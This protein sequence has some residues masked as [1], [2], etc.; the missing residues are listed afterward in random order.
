MED[1]LFKRLRLH[2]RKKLSFTPG[3]DR[4]RVLSACKDYLRLEN[5]MSLRYHR[6]GDSG[7][8]VAFARACMIDVLIE[9]LFAHVLK[10]LEEQTETANETVSVVALGGYGRAELCPL[11]D[12]DLMFLHTDGPTGDKYE[13]LQNA[14]SETL[15]YV[16]WDLGLNVGH[17]TRTIEESIE[18][19]TSSIKSKNAMLESRLVAGSKELFATFQKIYRD[20]CAADEPD[21]YF[22]DRIKDQKAR[23]KSHGGTVFLQE[24]NIKN[25]VGGL[26]DFQSVLWM[27][28]IKLG[29]GSLNALEKNQYLR[30]NE[31]RDFEQAYDFLLRVRNEIHFQ[32]KRPSETLSLER[33]PA[34]ALKLG[35]KDKNIFRRVESFMRDYYGAT[36]KIHQISVILEQRLT[37]P[38]A[39][40]GKMK[41]P[42]QATQSDKMVDGF[43]LR[44]GILSFQN[45]KIFAQDAERFIRVFRHS[46]QYQADLD[47]DLRNLVTESLPLLTGKIIRSPAANRSF[48]SL[49][50]TPGEVFKPLS[51]MHDLGVLGRFVPEFGALDCLVQHEYYHRYTADIHTLETIRQLDRI[52]DGQSHYAK[53]YH[54]EIHK[55]QTPGLLYIILLLHDIGKGTG[56]EGHAVQ[57]AKL[58]AGVIDRLQLSRRQKEQTLFII[59]NHLEMSRFWQKHDVDDP[60]AAE[61]FSEFIVDRETLRLLYVHTYCDTRGTADQM[62]NGFKDMLHTTLFDN[63]LTA[64]GETSEALQQAE[65]TLELL[66]YLV[67]QVEPA[68]DSLSKLVPE[69]S[70]EEVEAH[71]RHLPERY[72]SNSDIEEAALHI[73]MVHQLLSHIYQAEALDSLKPVIDWRDDLNLSITVVQIVTW[74][75][76]GLFYKLAGA[77]SLAGLSIMSSKAMSRDD[78]ITIDTF[79]VCEP[80]GGAVQSKKAREMF[81]KALHDTL[82]HDHDLMPQILKNAEKLSPP[83]YLLKKD[84]LPAEI[85]A[86]VEVYRDER[87]GKTFVEVIARDRIG[88]LHRI[89]K[90][91]S[92]HGFDIVFARVLTERG[93]A[94]D[95]FT[96]DEADSVSASGSKNLRDLQQNLE[97]VISSKN[98]PVVTN[99]R[100]NKK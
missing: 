64:L 88:L 37:R 87:L 74:D 58:A 14:L 54:R 52:F 69:I 7:R 21:K 39:K 6:N 92:R 46:Q 28:G 3:S 84:A 35:Y 43:L 66:E 61:Q 40:P 24:P 91:I 20:F 22:E 45:E 93:V 95:T 68:L 82:L 19:A 62:W 77:F 32:S 60:A 55:T 98:H 94:V 1:P 59:E 27:S 53:K 83:A 48:R 57:G 38:Y 26:R 12:I 79:Y 80:G 42:N 18:E 44:E 4:A 71:C 51:L 25:G 90:T 8:R 72:L 10:N 86:S 89:A 30:K 49:L 97:T 99:T 33:Q 67:R 31:R 76:L 36:R 41:S 13:P 17:S 100:N 75:R 50:L 65:P 2:A 23:R 96:I 81:T 29:E 56:V 85:P 63:T 11:S 16:L 78:H 73:R 47:F 5:Q 34:V 15:L 9:S 70:S